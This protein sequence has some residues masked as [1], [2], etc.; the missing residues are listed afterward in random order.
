MV[1]FRRRGDGCDGLCRY[2]RF[3]LEEKKYRL[4]ESLFLGG[5]FEITS[6]ALRLRIWSEMNAG[7][8]SNIL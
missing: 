1:N 8:D 4:V 5:P 2:F 7:N 6:R 3:E